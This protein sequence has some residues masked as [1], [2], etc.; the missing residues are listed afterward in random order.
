MENEMA[1]FLLWSSFMLLSLVPYTYAD[2]YTYQFGIATNY[3]VLPGA[4]ITV[5]AVLTNTGTL[6]IVFAPVLDPLNNPNWPRP[7]QLGGDVPGYTFGDVGDWIV[8]DTY[9][10]WPNVEA[11][12]AQFSGV[13]LDPGQSLDFNFLFAV[14]D[15]PVGSSASASCMNFWIYFTDNLEGNLASCPTLQF[16]IGTAAESSAMLYYDGSSANP[17]PSSQTP[18]PSSLILLA[19]GL[20]AMAHVVRSRINRS[21]TGRLN[22]PL[23]RRT[24]SI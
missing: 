24:F 18:E 5:P 3:Q 16:T 20:V 14:A 9:S 21:A 1:R 6:P 2:N 12:F 23:M 8:G 11:F 19:T 4:D 10:S 22:K 17:V 15:L 13:T 7:S